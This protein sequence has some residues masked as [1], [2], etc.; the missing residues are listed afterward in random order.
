MSWSSKSAKVCIVVV[1]LCLACCSSSAV[2]AA[3]KPPI[4]EGWARALIEQFLMNPRNRV[5]VFDRTG[6]YLSLLHEE[7]TLFRPG[8][9]NFPLG[10]N[11][12]DWCRTLELPE[13]QVV[14][15]IMKIL[16]T[17]IRGQGS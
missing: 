11:F 10:I 6:E 17:F 13:D 8:S 15:W 1:A 16:T 2:A 3:E 12:L 5:C 4:E 9:D 14:G 7:F